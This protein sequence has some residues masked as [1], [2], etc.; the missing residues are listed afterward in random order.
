MRGV[1]SIPCPRCGAGHLHRSRGMAPLRW[2]ASFV[3]VRRYRCRAC[4]AVTWQRTTHA[5]IANTPKRRR[6]LVILAGVVIAVG[7]FAG[8][9][10]IYLAGAP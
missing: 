4:G 5:T 2:L 6:R 3:R 9:S 1:S 8:L 10:V 7:A